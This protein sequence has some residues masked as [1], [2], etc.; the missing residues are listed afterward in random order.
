MNND[1]PGWID[2]T[3]IQFS[4][5]QVIWRWLVFPVTTMAF[6]TP[7]PT[8]PLTFR[9]ESGELVRMVRRA[10]RTD[11]ATTPPPMWGIPGFNPMRF[12][13]PATNHD[14]IYNTHYVEIS[15]DCGVTWDTVEVTREWAD[16]L[17]A[18]MIEYDV[19]PGSVI[20]RRAYHRGVAAFGWL[21]W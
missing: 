3:V 20:M 7:D 9:R 13:L 12:L 15:A 10:G 11:F 18:E 19:D 16:D 8:K 17:L 21:K 4:D 1:K 14:M 2:S 6:S 5:P